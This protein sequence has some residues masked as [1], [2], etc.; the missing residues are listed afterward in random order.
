MRLFVPTWSC[1]N[2]VKGSEHLANTEQVFIALLGCL[3][4][5]RILYLV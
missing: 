4:K 5:G 3:Q 1:H 2:D